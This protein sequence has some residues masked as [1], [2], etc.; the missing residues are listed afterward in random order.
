MIHLF[1]RI[2]HATDYILVSVRHA[3]GAKAFARVRFG[4]L[5]AIVHYLTI[6]QEGSLA[7]MLNLS[8][9]TPLLSEEP[10]AFRSRKGIYDCSHHL[11]S[12][13]VSMTITDDSGRDSARKNCSWSRF[14][15]DWNYT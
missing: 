3:Y 6:S 8:H 9:V 7:P 15:H 5:C 13:V 12:A 2:L 14:H 11:S 1:Y 10:W 4:S